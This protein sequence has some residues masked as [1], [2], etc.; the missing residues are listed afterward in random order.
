MI[1][2]LHNSGDSLLTYWSH[3][4][5]QRYHVSVTKTLV[6]FLLTIFSVSTGCLSVVVMN[7]MLTVQYPSFSRWW[8][9]AGLNI[10]ACLDCWCL[11]AKYPRDQFSVNSFRMYISILSS[12]ELLHIQWW[13]TGDWRQRYAL[14]SLCSR[15]ECSHCKASTDLLNRNW[16]ENRF[17]LLV[18]QPGLC[19]TVGG[20]WCPCTL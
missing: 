20:W 3:E 12:P 10:C 14:Q 16:R 13:S 17:C 4:Y 6:T 15:A 7:F 18:S 5:Q 1:L 9:L 11:Q 2:I 19:Q 8:D